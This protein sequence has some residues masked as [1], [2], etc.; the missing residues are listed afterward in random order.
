MDKLL[1]VNQCAELTA[2]TPS[3][4]RKL[5]YHHRIPY[6]KVGRLTRIRQTDLE[7]WVRLGLRAVA[8]PST[9]VRRSR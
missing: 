4:W 3:F 1:T 7:A 6:V 9:L 8:P 2:T 5:L